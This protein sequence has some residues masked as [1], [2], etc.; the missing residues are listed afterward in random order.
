MSASGQRLLQQTVIMRVGERSRRRE[1]ASRRR[2]AGLLAVDGAIETADMGARM[3]L[4]WRQ[5]M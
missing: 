2:G 4:P 1:V 5:S 3:L